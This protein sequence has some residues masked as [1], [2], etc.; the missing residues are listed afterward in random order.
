[1]TRIYKKS[2]YLNKMHE[3][4]GVMEGKLCDTCM[5][6]TNSRCRLSTGGKYHWNR[7][8]Q[9]C[10]RWVRDT[11]VDG[12]VWIKTPDGWILRFKGAK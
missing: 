10:G 7:C 11:G 6:F 2:K 1:M 4:Y 3:T 9:A 5:Y 12:F 8:W